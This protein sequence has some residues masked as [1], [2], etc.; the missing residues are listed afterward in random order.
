MKTA[1]RKISSWDEA[2]DLARST[3]ARGG[4]VVFTN[5]VFDLLHPGHVRYLGDARAMG[6]ALV[7]AINS[8]RSVRA[9]KGP[10]RP[11]TPEWER[12]EVLLA[13]AS[14]DAVVIFED[15][16]PQEVIERIQPDILVKGEDWAAD[17]IVGRELVEA[18]GGRVVRIRL[19]QGL[20]TTELIRRIR[21]R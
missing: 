21:R 12:A 9:N 8:D 2:A 4:T 19:E 10:E 20:S 7:V 6:D 13:L 11:I 5:G 17:A 16:T 1:P 3:Q 18:R 15:E 14:V